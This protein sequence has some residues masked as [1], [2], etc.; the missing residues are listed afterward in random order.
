MST[1]AFCSAERDARRGDRAP[2]AA[3][4][5]RD[6]VARR[7]RAPDRRSVEEAAPRPRAEDRAGHEAAG[8]KR[9][10]LRAARAH[11]LDGTAA[12]RRRRGGSVREL[13][14]R[15]RA[16]RRQAGRRGD[17]VGRQAEER[18]SEPDAHPHVRIRVARSDPTERRHEGD[19]VERRADRQGATPRTSHR[20][21][22]ARPAQPVGEEGDLSE[23]GDGADGHR[24]RSRGERSTTRCATTSTASRGIACPADRRLPAEVLRRDGRSEVPACRWPEVV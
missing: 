18:R 13:A 9:R 19:R 5:H 15:T 8:G 2:A 4:L 10:R 6:R 17:A 24:A 21:R 1:V 14:R 16:A 23:A 12:A 22:R 11:P 3:L 7:D 20:D